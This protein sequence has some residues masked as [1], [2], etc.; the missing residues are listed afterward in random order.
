MR[1]LDFHAPLSLV[2][3]VVILVVAVH[4]PA[5]AVVA[6]SVLLPTATVT[7]HFAVR[8]LRIRQD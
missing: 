5:A 1:A 3:V 4:D 7:G 2:L 8:Y 6:A